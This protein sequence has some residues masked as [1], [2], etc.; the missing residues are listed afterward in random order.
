MM[1]GAATEKG[2]HL[3]Y[4]HIYISGFDRVDGA[5]TQGSILLKGTWTGHLAG[6]NQTYDLVVEP[7]SL[8]YISV[9]GKQHNNHSF[10]F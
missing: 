10:V 6:E 4:Q 1:V 5:L 9:W 2:Q 7:P 8:L 3:L